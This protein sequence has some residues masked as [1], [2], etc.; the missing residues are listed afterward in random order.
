[1][2]IA[3]IYQNWFFDFL[4]TIVMNPKSHPEYHQGSVPVFDNSPTMVIY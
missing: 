4:K 1:L 2:R 3:V